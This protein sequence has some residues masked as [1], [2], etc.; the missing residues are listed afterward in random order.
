MNKSSLKKF[1]MDFYQAW[2]ERDT[3]KVA[4]FYDKNVKAHVDFKP[5][6]LEDMMNRLQ[7]SYKK[8]SKVE[9]NVQDIFVDEEEGKIAVRMKQLYVFR[10]TSEEHTCQSITLYRIANQKIQEIWMSFYPNVDYTNN[11]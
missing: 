2:K 10:E 9:Y 3:D 6:T 8:F 1:I 5:V 4:N 11:D 7:F